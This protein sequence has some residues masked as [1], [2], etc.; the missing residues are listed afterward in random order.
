MSRYVSMSDLPR[1][2]LSNGGRECPRPDSNRPRRR[3][4]SVLVQAPDVAGLRGL[5]PGRCGALAWVLSSLL[6]RGGAGISPAGLPDCL[7]WMLL[8][9]AL[10]H[11][12]GACVIPSAV[13]RLLPCVLPPV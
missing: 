1:T 7:R 5:G 8:I 3:Y 4:A 12:V 6:L 9:S 10:V 13:S 2:A 11:G